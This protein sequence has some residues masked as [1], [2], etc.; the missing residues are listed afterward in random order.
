MRPLGIRRLRGGAEV[1]MSAMRQPWILGIAGLVVLCVPVALALALRGGSPSRT[2]STSAPQQAGTPALPPPDAVVLARE[3]GNDALTIAAERKDIRVTLFDGEGQGVNGQSVSVAGASAVPCGPGCYAAQTPARGD[4]PVVVGG[5]RFVFAIPRSVPDASVLMRRA[6][7]AFRSLRSVTYVER[8]AS[9]IHDHIVSTFTLE[10]PNRVEYRINNGTAGIVIGTRRWDRTSGKWVESSSTL[11][12]QPVP[13]WGTRITNAHVLARTPD[14]LVLSFLNPN[15][16][17]W[18][19][20]RFDARTMLPRRFDMIAAA[21]FM[22]HRYT[23][24]NAPRKIF[25]PR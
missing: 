4:V 20:V 9:S 25:P 18:F 5:R 17:A 24:F 2:P 19:D 8:L 6:S 11:L 1:T 3:D 13:V 7:N 16:P 22:H 21:H 15:V 10:A 14:T 23:S 12:P